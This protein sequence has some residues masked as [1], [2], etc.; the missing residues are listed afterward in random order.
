MIQYFRLACHKLVLFVPGQLAE[1]P[2]S[3][4]NLRSGVELLTFPRSAALV[5]V[6]STALKACRTPAHKTQQPVNMRRQQATC[7]AVQAKV[8]AA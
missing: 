7:K 8:T 3:I 1:L 2:E 6:T 5:R 4:L